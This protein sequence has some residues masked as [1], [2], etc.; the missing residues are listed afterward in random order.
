LKK[1][2]FPLRFFR[3]RSALGRKW[4][5]G[6]TPWLWLLP[7]FLFISVYL[8]YPVIETFR[9]SLLNANSSKFVGIS[10]YIEIFTN[11]A[12]QDTLL[13]NLL[14]L[15]LFTAL[16][17]G[18]GLLFATLAGRVRYESVAKGIIFIPMAISFVAAAVIWR[19][20]Y[21]YQPAG[22]TQ[23][24]LLNAVA[25]G[26]GLPPEPW[27]SAQSL[28]FSN[29]TF[30]SPLHTN[31]VAVIAV[32]VWMWTGFAMVVIS[33]GL[34]GISKEVIEAARVDGANEFQIFRRIIFP[35][36]S[37]TIVLVAT[38]LVIQALK[39][40]D[41]VWVM[42]AG[43]YNTDVIA[44]M[45]YK[46]LFNYQNF[47]KAGALAVILLLSIIPIMLISINRFRSQEETR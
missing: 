22:F 2:W 38:T 6:F 4:K 37:P 3:S 11:P 16:A 43:N 9:I 24:G 32:G 46:Q 33:A 30:P 45:M 26:V 17:V 40:F 12:M 44:T 10:N 15:V 23:F 27:I 25:T 19:F 13:N 47:G 41:V 18:L 20:V 14:W 7:A 8:I 28:P 35:L 29:V 34:K 1:R 5:R 36:V 21:A 42:T 39:I 31:N